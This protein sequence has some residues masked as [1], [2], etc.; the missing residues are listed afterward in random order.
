MF[1]EDYPRFAEVSDLT[2][3]P[4]R[5]N[6][7]YEAVFASN[8]DIFDGARVLDLASHDGRYSFAAL[9]AGAA[10]VTGVEVRQSLID[11]AQEVFAF[12]GQDPE[13]YRF[14]CGDVFEVLAREKFDV[15]V[16]L[17]LGYLYHTYRH[18]E[19]MYRLHEVAPQH[20]ILDTMVTPGTEPTLRVIGEPN[21]EDI[22]SASRDDYS[23][24]R[25]LVLRPSVPATQM[26]MHAFGF[27][28]ESAYDW[29]NRLAGRPIEAGL[30]GYARGERVTLRCRFRPEII[31]ATW[32]P[33][34]PL[35]G[36]EG[37]PEP[38]RETSPAPDAAPDAAPGAAPAES[39]GGWRGRINQALAKATGYE[40][41]RAPTKR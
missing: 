41:R 12:Y 38:T 3:Q 16:V 10:H 8:S 21:V 11:K 24:G 19:L 14:V 32:D 28:I 30:K 23:V 37:P 4:H 29:R 25:V 22:R 27:E 5:M 35:P 1:A 31:A 18:T 26:L 40:L 20:L 17:C 36:L 6:E 33:M 2:P 39:P 7:R 34:A 13:T 15:D 9:K